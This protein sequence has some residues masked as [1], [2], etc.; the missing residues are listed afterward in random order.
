MSIIHPNCDKTRKF[1]TAHLTDDIRT[2]ALKA[3]S[4]K[5]ID[6]PFALNQISG[7]Q[8]ART[9]LPSWAATE[10]LIYPPHLSME[11]CSSESTALYK[12]RLVQR[13]MSSFSN[14]LPPQATS[15]IDLTGGFGVDFSFMARAFDKAVYVEQQE[16]LCLVAQNNFPLFG[17]EHTDIQIVN[18][19]G[20]S[21][22]HQ[23]EAATIIFLDPARRDDCGGKTVFIA[24]CTPDVL[25][26]EAELLSKSQYLVLKLSPM[27]DWH[28]AVDDLNQ[29]GN[30]V[31]EVHI[32]SV[33]NE[34]KELLLVLQAEEKANFSNTE[35]SPLRLFCVNDDQLVS[36]PFRASQTANI[37]VFIDDLVP[38]MYLYEPNAS[39]MKAGCF[40][41]ITQQY[42]VSALAPNSHLFISTNEIADFPGRSFQISAISSMNKKELKRILADI[43][44]ANIAVRNF[45]L[46][47]ADLRK[48]LKLRDGGTCYLFAT[49]L[50]NGEHTL[51]R[52]VKIGNK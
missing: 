42:P 28:K 21:Y 39:L 11:Q 13:L 36:F 38:D 47:V 18:G 3:S 2:L 40:G 10:G 29:L 8:K 4:N 32:L 17:Y 52:C 26:V 25:S 20:I 12:A 16:K 30:V 27:L 48:R 37:R 5:D 22:L 44:Q 43:T 45:P 34:C 24:D 41:V 9:K 6:L 46:S 1:I 23:T 19:D 35:N 14:S 51:L 49:T 7:W 50:Q 33:K 31:R 15:L